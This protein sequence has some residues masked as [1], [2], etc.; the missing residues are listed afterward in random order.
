M[1]TFEIKFIDKLYVAHIFKL[2]I[3]GFRDCSGLEASGARSSG[4]V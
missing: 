2:L 3:L 1:L 4:D